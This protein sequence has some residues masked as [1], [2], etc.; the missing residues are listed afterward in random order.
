MNQIKQE[1]IFVM[2]ERIKSFVGGHPIKIYKNSVYDEKI[3]KFRGGELLVEIPYSGALLNAYSNQ[4]DAASI[5]FNDTEIPT[6][7]P[8]VFTDVD[9]L[10]DESECEFC[11]VS[12]LYVAACKEL[13]RDTSRLLTIGTPVVDE[14]GVVIGTTALNRN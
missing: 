3:R 4:E 6:K 8:L 10:P 1:G 14:N 13:G 7:T 5:P 11:V 2:K 9:P 12:A